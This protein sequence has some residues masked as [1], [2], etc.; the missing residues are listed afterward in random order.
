MKQKLIR[1]FLGIIF[2]VL[3]LN[4][5]A[6]ASAVFDEYITVTQSSGKLSAL[7]NASYAG[8]DADNPSAYLILTV[9]D[10]S[11]L[12]GIASKKCTF[13]SVGSCP[14]SVTYDGEL[15][16]GM[17]AKA[18][19][20]SGADNL[21]PI[22][23][24]SKSVT[25]ST[26]SMHYPLDSYF[27]DSEI[28]TM[29]E[30]FGDKNALWVFADGG[31]SDSAHSH[32]DSGSF[33]FTLGGVKWAVDLGSEPA[34]YSRSG[35]N[36]AQNAG[37]SD[38]FYYR[39][40]TEGHNCVVIN[41]DNALETDKNAFAKMS[42]PVSGIGGA[43]AYVD[44]TDTYTS[45]KVKNYIRGY[46]VSEGRRAFT[47]RDE[48][49]LTKDDSEVWWFMH[50]NADIEITDKT[51]VIL[52]SGGKKLKMQFIAD[53]DSPTYELTVMPQKRFI[54]LGFFEA[55]NSGKKIALKVRASGKLNITVKMSMNGEPQS[56]SPPESN[57]ISKWSVR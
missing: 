55:K 7:V 38:L 9:Y 17:T 14:I 13:T 3:L 15:K 37:Y 23:V 33:Q 11:S 41:P 48:I 21:K 2:A 10:G 6:S 22:N 43:Y 30:S 12:S 1:R 47:V 36:Y 16:A 19:L 42:R 28:I 5:K 4:I 39:M 44:L 20:W 52:S 27:R 53:G 8:S 35:G 54:D 25:V 49:E 26:A 56:F 51:T 50:T 57:P 29:R 34:H 46:L 18:F 40:K 31:K 45:Y 24:K 32:L